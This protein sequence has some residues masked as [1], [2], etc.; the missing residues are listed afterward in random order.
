MKDK[1]KTP[2]PLWVLV[3]PGLL[4]LSVPTVNGCTLAPISEECLG[5]D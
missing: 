4:A 2:S 5:V 3:K 1:V